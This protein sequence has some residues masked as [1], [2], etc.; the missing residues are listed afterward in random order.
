MAE[1]EESL[2]NNRWKII[3]I[4]GLI[5]ILLVIFAL[6][7]SYIA[8]RRK[9]SNYIRIDDLSDIPEPNNPKS[10]LAEESDNTRNDYVA[11][12]QKTRAEDAKKCE[13]SGKYYNNNTNNCE[14]ML[15]EIV[16]KKCIEAKKRYDPIENKCKDFPPRPQGQSPR[17]M[18][19]DIIDISAIPDND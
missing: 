8:Y 5:L 11:Y 6:V 16:E 19:S 2:F 18:N 10:T 12:V 13:D 3:G 15:E 17:S 4:G 1:I 14:E 7:I 9:K